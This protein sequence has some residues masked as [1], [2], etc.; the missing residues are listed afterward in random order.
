MEAV[1]STKSIRTAVLDLLV[2]TTVYLVPSA[3]HM[4]GLPLYLVDPMRLLLFFT[5][6]TTGRTN[7]LF[8]ALSLP[9]FSTLFSGHPV[10]PKNILISL[11]LITN[12]SLFY[13]LVGRGSQQW[14]AGAISVLLSKV[15]Y[16]SLKAL[17]LG[18][19]L[20][21]GALISTVWYFQ[22]LPLVLISAALYLNSLNRARGAR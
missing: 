21:S 4:L 22:L 2:V 11:E 5:V 13:W 10:F 1:L 8:M 12:A 3:S 19:G 17:I 20:M 18:L 16:Y 6:L 14:L 9:F 15:V 7:V